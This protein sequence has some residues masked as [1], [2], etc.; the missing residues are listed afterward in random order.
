MTSLPRILIVDDEPLAIQVLYNALGDLGDLSFALSGAQA[1]EQVAAT[2]PDL[3]LLDARMPGLDGFATCEALKARHPE[4]PVL[5]V[6]ADGDPR[7]ELRA[8]TAGAADFIVKPINP[9]LVRARVEAHLRL[10]RQQR[11]YQ[12]TVE[13][14]RHSE[15]RFRK[16][17]EDTLQATALYQDGR[18][19]AVNR[20]ALG[21]LGLERA[22]QMLG[23]TLAALSPPRQPDGRP[24]AEKACELIDAAFAEGSAAFE[25]QL[26]RGDGRPFLAQFLATPIDQDGVDLLHLVFSDI[27]ARKAV[28]AAL[29]RNRADL[30]EAQALAHIGSWTV[31]LVANRMEWSAEVYRI[32]GMEPGT[33]V[34]PDTHFRLIH[35]EDLSAFE[36]A[37]QAT[38]QGAPYDITHR[39]IVDGQVKWVHARATITF[40]PDGQPLSAIGTLQ[41]VTA[42]KA[43]QVEIEY[44]AYNDPLTGLLNRAAGQERLAHDLAVAKR[45]R[46]SLVLLFMDLDRFKFVNDRYGHATG[47][48]L[49]QGV[50]R[51]LRDC[52]RGEDTL[53][54]LSG[55]EFM[56]LLT[57]LSAEHL[58]AQV[59]A[60]CERILSTLV[61][62]FSLGGHQLTTSFSIG[63][64]VFPQDGQT[65]ETLMRNADTALYAAK[66]A[67]RNGYRFFEPG[68]NAALSHFTSTRDALRRAL[69][70][71]E[72]ELHY[73][74]QV[75]LRSG[76]VVGVEALTRWR[77]PGVG[78]VMPDAFI[79]VAEESGLIIPLGRWVLREACRQA[80]A[81]CHDGPAVPVMALNLSALQLHHAGLDEEVRQALTT[82]GLDPSRLELELTEIALLSPQTGC[83]AMLAAWRALGLHLAIDNFGTGSS[84]IPRLKRLKVDKLKIDRSFIRDLTANPDDH[85]LVPAMIQLAHALNIRTLAEGVENT[86]QARLLRALG[87]DEAQGYLFA[88]PLPAAEVESWLRAHSPARLDG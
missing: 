80:V 44:L 81:W 67:G 35:P 72:L 9:P 27:T 77:R 28:E 14:L 17:F 60:T 7:S 55:D 50:A 18:F 38:L 68:M 86:D 42:Q 43:A 51:R 32:S 41:D 36:D 69:D 11:D 6:T 20:A 59:S 85:A 82:S 54:R 33:P 21:L 12:A 84:S 65:G 19:A 24:S 31:D 2:P 48:L 25:W 76:R 26:S 39:I 62:P 75:D 52:L 16:L 63:V 70:Q 71:G 87:C 74:P 37:W 57:T 15:E 66:K 73:Q 46:T 49:L 29:A 22:D 8:L 78:L 13:R 1:L 40:D 5:F 47:D 45:E 79:P 10:R 34:A 61:Q 64:A 3:V 53:C 56:I 58:V 30:E 23:Q 83:Q 88:K 4:L